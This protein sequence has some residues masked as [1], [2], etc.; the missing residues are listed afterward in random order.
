[1]LV[2]V[3][4]LGACRAVEVIVMVVVVVGTFKRGEVSSPFL[5]SSNK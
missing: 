1:M 2:L 3:L 4:R 5:T